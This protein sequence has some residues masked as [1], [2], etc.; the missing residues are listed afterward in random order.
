MAGQ[1]FFMNLFKSDKKGQLDDFSPAIFLMTLTTDR[2]IAYM[3]LGKIGKPTKG[4]N[5]GIILLA[6]SPLTLII[7]SSS[8]ARRDNP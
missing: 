7:I 2:P 6:F 1:I 8:G 4:E 5:Q 3:R